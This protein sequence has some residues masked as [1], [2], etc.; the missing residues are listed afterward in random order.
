VG[1]GRGASAWGEVGLGTDASSWGEVGLGTDA[2]SWGEDPFSRMDVNR[3]GMVDR[4]ESKEWFNSDPHQASYK[5]GV[6]IVRADDDDAEEWKPKHKL[7][8]VDR[9]RSRYQREAGRERDE[10]RER[11]G[12]SGVTNADEGTHRRRRT[13]VSRILNTAARSSVQGSRVGNRE[14]DAY[15]V[16]ERAHRATQ[17]QY[18]DMTGGSYRQRGLPRS[19]RWS[20]ADKEGRPWTNTAALRIEDAKRRHSAA[21]Q[22]HMEA[23]DKHVEII[24]WNDHRG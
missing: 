17:E 20:G 6:P 5:G 14:R 12:R 21:M 15:D 7:A 1:L 19:P 3:D 9:D 23:M 11:W 22:S 10:V 18:A 8:I 13:K 4:D 16:A 2:S 24:N